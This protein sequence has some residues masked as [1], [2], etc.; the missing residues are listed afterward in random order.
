MRAIQSYLPKPRHT[1]VHRIFVTADPATAWQTARHFDGASIPW[2]RMLFD[3]RDLPNVIRGKMPTTKDRRLGVD[4]VADNAKGFIILH[5]IP[6]KEVVVGAVGKFWHLQIPFAEVMP[7]QFATFDEPGWGKLAWAIS[8]EPYLNGTTISFELRTTATD[9][10]SWKK[11]NRYY[12][13]IAVGSYPIRSSFMSHL[14]MQLGKMKFPEDEIADFP[15]ND[16]IPDAKYQ[17]T[18]HKNIEAPPSAVWQYL[19]QLG[20]DRAGWYSIDALDNGGKPSIDHLVKG[21][22][23]RAVGDQLAATPAKN[24][25]YEVYAVEKEKHFIIGGETD[26]IGG[27]F[28]MTWSFILL[29]VGEDATHLIS[30]ARMVSSPKWAQWFMGSILYPPIHQLMSEV[31]LRNIKNMTERDAQLRVAFIEEPAYAV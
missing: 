10:W 16:L 15:G 5:E 8:V 28:K 29:P 7:D 9:E 11:L 4:Q 30:N 27:P 2:V 22:E 3:L 25:F 14:Q 24:S 23:T 18:F 19:M 26:R 6:G 31:Q 20:C 1:E 17:L 12:Q 13:L 21:W